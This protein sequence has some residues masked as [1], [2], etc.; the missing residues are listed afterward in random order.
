VLLGVGLGGYAD[1]RR[2]AAAIGVLDVERQDRSGLGEERHADD[3]RPLRAFAHHKYARVAQ[4]GDGSLVIGSE[5]DA[6][7][8]AGNR[9][10]L[11]GA[12]AA[13]QHAAREQREKLAT[14]D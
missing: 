11:I 2:V 7:D 13:E 1:L 12:R 9:A 14:L 5:A 4:A 10:G 8:A 6:G 3:G